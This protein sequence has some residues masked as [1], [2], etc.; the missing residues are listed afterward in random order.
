MVLVV[1]RYREGVM[2]KTWVMA[3]LSFSPSSF[4]TFLGF[5]PIIPAESRPSFL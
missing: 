4:P 2:H 5:I 1:T 3:F